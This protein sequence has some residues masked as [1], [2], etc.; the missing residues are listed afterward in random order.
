ML[1]AILLLIYL[2]LVFVGQ[3]LLSDLLGR[4]NGVV[5][6]VSTLLVAA[7]FRPLRQQIQKLVDR[8]FYRRKYDASKI[9]EA[10]S[11]TLR[12]EVNLNQLRGHLL[13]VVQE[14]MQPSHV[15]LWLREPAS[16]SSRSDYMQP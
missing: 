15:S 13:T 2:L 1:T 5:L 6:V 9:V 14:T 10:F 3:Y 4:S 12:N 16:K 7:L 11:A 8:R